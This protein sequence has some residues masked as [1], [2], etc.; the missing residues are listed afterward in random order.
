MHAMSETAERYGT[1]AAG[2]TERL[3]NVD[4]EQWSASTPC[5]DWSVR[6]LVVHVI[7]TQRRVMTRFDDVSPVE[8]DPNG[9]LLTQWQ[10][11]SGAV[12]EAVGDD[13]R[14]STIVG[15]MF[16][17]QP[18]ESLVGRMVCTDLLVHTWDLA[19]ATGQDERLDPGAV[20]SAGGFLAS[21]DDAIRVPGGFAEKITPPPQADA[22]TRFLNFAGRA[23]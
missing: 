9:D 4:P 19:R 6:D 5:P 13:T 3:V 14:A 1:I 7:D 17:E 18:F 16:G 11:A 15:G 8:T 23:F 20:S 2:F 12:A 10:A 22:Q 21:I